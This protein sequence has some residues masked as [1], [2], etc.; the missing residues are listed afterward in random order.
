MHP[1]EVPAQPTR[2][3]R[4]SD[5]TWLSTTP[6][7]MR[8]G[9]ETA[10][11]ETAVMLLVNPVEYKHSPVQAAQPTAVTA[12]SIDADKGTRFP[13]TGTVHAFL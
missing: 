3:L 6:L 5:A 13:L 2:K 11:A 7:D 12:Q 1:H 10:P 4:S 9:S 8:A